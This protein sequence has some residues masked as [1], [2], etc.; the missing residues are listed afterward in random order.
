MNRCD[1]KEESATSIARFQNRAD[2]EAFLGQVRLWNRV[3]GLPAIQVDSMADGE[4][5]RVRTV[6]SAQRGLARLIEA[7]GGVSS[8]ITPQGPP[9]RT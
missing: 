6:P 1:G 8:W 2:R 9:A 4:R 5:V 3:E 7:F